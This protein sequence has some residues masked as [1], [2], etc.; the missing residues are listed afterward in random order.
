MP[1]V[2]E[3]KVV[4]TKTVVADESLAS[5]VG[6]HHTIPTAL[7]DLVDNSLDAGAAHVLIRFVQDGTRIVSMMVIDDGSGMDNVAI[8]SAMTYGRRRDYA[9][10]DLGHFGVGMKAASLS[11][12]RVLRVWSRATGHPAVGREI[13]SASERGRQGVS[14]IDGDQATGFFGSVTPRFPLDTGTIV[15]WR[16]ISTFLMSAHV[17]EQT[18]W[19]E[20]TIND[21]RS[22][23]GIVFHRLIESRRVAVTVDVFDVEAG[24]AGALRAV[25]AIDPFKYPVAGA[26]K[27]PRPL[28]VSLDGSTVPAAAHLW[29]AR[30]NAPEFRL[31]GSPGREHQGIY[32]YRH[33]R[34]L[35]VGGW[36]G[37]VRARPDLGLARIAIE[38]DDNLLQR[39]TINPEKSGVT[40]DATASAAIDS[41]VFADGDGGF[42]TYLG[43][44]EAAVRAARSHQPRPISVI[45]P[46]SGFPEDVLDSF[47]DAFDF[48]VGEDP[49]AVGWRALAR[50]QFF[51]VD[52]KTRTLW[53]NARFRR[54]LLG[55]RSL[56]P[57]DAPVLKSLIFLLVSEMFEGVRI[58]AR[59]K[60][61]MDAW[62]EVLIAAIAAHR[63]QVAL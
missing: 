51:E 59:Q 27:Y 39:I 19:L 23:V 45:E 5:A 44:A 11:Q 42:R 30:S 6:L 16:G 50:D 26:G 48:T 60:E 25:N 57:T 33:E 62:Q 28:T 10:A 7:A 3:I 37:I 9:A 46:V 55:H 12:A 2:S 34:L 56:N 21:V 35:Q 15:E 54:D 49:V 41:A 24:R 52:L 63:E 53:I 31:H 17:D 43:D 29:P 13:D 47:S 32:F 40:L 36:N 22:H 8:D 18:S 61:K 1:D 58:S 14:V 20:Q 38:L 4:G